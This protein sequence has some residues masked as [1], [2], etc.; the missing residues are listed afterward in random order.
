MFV[1]SWGY[2]IYGVFVLLLLAIAVLL[3]W[4][5]WAGIRA[6]N[7]VTDERRMRMALLLAEDPES[8]AE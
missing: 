6:L 2:L 3:I 1:A 4:L 7:A 8:E 5:M